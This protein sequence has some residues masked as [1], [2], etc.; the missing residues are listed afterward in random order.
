MANLFREVQNLT[1]AIRQF[2]R[3]TSLNC[4]SNSDIKI[5]INLIFLKSKCIEN[6]GNGIKLEVVLICQKMQEIN[7]F[8]RK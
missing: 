7:I 3:Q 1:A 2:D 6:N 4:V 5:F 8:T